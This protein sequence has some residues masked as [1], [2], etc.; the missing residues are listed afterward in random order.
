MLA[1]LTFHIKLPQ[2]RNS[3]IR[4]LLWCTRAAG[5]VDSSKLFK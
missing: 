4:V 1:G 3:K 5:S 2:V